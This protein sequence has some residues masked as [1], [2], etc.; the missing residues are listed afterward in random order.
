MKKFVLNAS[1]L[2]ATFGVFAQQANKVSLPSKQVEL[3]RAAAERNNNHPKTTTAVNRAT[4]S[5][6]FATFNMSGGSN[7]SLPTGVT[8]GTVAGNAS[9]CR[10]KWA[11]SAS[12]SPF[13]VGTLNSTSASNGWMIFD[14]DSIGLALGAAQQ[15]AWF[16]VGPVNCT[17]KTQIELS[18][19]ERYRMFDDSTYVAVSNNGGGS[20]TTYPISKHVNLGNND[21]SGTANPVKVL[22]DISATAGNQANVL[23]RFYFFGNNNNV[24]GYQG[25]Y[26][27]LV[28]DVIFGDGFTADPE[29]TQA[30]FFSAHVSTPLAIVD[31]LRFAGLVDNGGLA[32]AN[33]TYASAVLNS[34]NTVI[35]GTVF[36]AP[37]MMVGA[38]AVDSAFMI[39]T[40]NFWKPLVTGQY[41]VAG[42]ITAPGD[43]ST[44]NNVDTSLFFITDTVLNN[45]FGSSNGFVLPL[46]DGANAARL[47]G[48]GFAFDVPA[49]ASATLSHMYAAFSNASSSNTTLGAK[50]VGRIIKLDAS[51][52][53][54][55]VIAG[56]DP[57]TLTAADITTGSTVSIRNI[58]RLH[59]LPSQ[60]ITLTQGS[61]VAQVQPAQSEIDLMGNTIWTLGANSYRFAVN[62][63]DDGA[64]NTTIS[65]M[66]NTT[67]V[68]RVSFTTPANGSPFVLGTSDVDVVNSLQVVPN[69]SNGVFQFA[70][71]TTNKV[72]N[73]SYTVTAANGQVITTG[74]KKVNNLT[75]KGEVDLSKYPSGIYN[76][77]IVVD[78]QTLSKK[79]TKN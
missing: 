44:A 77:E 63:T 6:P 66:G 13:N 50:V 9:F 14:S 47:Q 68:L 3:V 60:S 12:I 10:W 76:L 72:S 70:L 48:V 59:K 71:N 54:E 67:P 56:T 49:G 42:A 69:P 65:R 46:I 2:F 74:T 61:Y 75:F 1:L 33:V 28:D 39:P 37:A 58:G 8:A 19:E 30:C 51:G 20:W 34:T 52:N 29:V 4:R 22:M 38:Q 18:F 26:S 36:T 45:D 17:G 79:L 43:A 57:Y 15:H 27:W 25:S 41:A 55:A 16:Q 62:T 7:T 11:N 35:P 5:T 53:V 23:V 31:T 78:G 73:L 64:A 21:F 32:G 24:T 40:N